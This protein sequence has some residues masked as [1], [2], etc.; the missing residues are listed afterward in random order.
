[1]T[2]TTEYPWCRHGINKSGYCAECKVA[3]LI[4]TIESLQKEDAEQKELLLLSQYIM[5]FH[6]MRCPMNIDNNFSGSEEHLAMY[7]DVRDLLEPYKGQVDWDKWNA[8]S[9]DRIRA[10]NEKRRERHRRM[11]ERQERESLSHIQEE[12]KPSEGVIGKPGV[13]GAYVT[14]FTQEVKP[15]ELCAKCKRN[16]KHLSAA[17]CEPCIL[18]EVEKS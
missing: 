13:H 16:P 3:S 9:M 15:L 11:L 1:M 4:T 8:G 18:Q 10:S 14:S 6:T 5:S 7:R 17:L 2:E 12:T